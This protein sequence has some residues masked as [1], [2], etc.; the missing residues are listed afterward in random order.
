MNLFLSTNC[1]KLFTEMSLIKTTN[2]S[3]QFLGQKYPWTTVCLD[4]SLIG[5]LC[6]WTKVP[7]TTFSMD[8]GPLL[9]HHKFPD[10]SNEYNLK[11]RTWS[12]SATQQ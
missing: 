2:T 1:A 12:Y 9:Q 3:K 4:N 11:W 8:I 10:P 6:H 5:Q 7:W